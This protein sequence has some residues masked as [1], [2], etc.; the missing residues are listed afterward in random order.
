MV[1]FKLGCQ[2]SWARKPNE[3]KGRKDWSAGPKISRL[4][5]VTVSQLES[6]D[7][8]MCPRRGVSQ[9]DFASNMPNWSPRIALCMSIRVYRWGFRKQGS[10]VSA[11][12]LLQEVLEN[13]VKNVLKDV[14]T[15]PDGHGH[16]YPEW[17]GQATFVVPTVVVLCHIASYFWQG[18]LCDQKIKFHQC[19]DF[20]SCTEY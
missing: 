4:V 19:K 15:S 10:R 20:L 2:V 7:K 5:S 11:S 12:D 8:T 17:P 6:R 18:H 16:F 9:L 14:L 3:P 1:E 13:M